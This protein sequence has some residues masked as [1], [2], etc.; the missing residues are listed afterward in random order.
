MALSSTQKRKLSIFIKCFV[1]SL[2]AWLLFALSNSYT[3]TK[4]TPVQYV[5]EPSS[6]AIRALQSDTVRVKLE[7][8]GWLILF[9]SLIRE[10]Q[11][12][13]VDLSGLENRSMVL[14]SNQIGFINR[15]FPASQKVLAVSPDT[16]FFDF[17]RQYEKRVP[18][19]LVQQLKFEKQYGIIGEVVS[20]PEYVTLFGPK[21]EVEQFESWKTDTLFASNLKTSLRRRVGLRQANSGNVRVYPHQVEVAVPVG[22]VTE[23]TFEIP[24]KAIN[25]SEYRNIRLVPSKVK[26]TALVSL[27][28]FHTLTAENFEI[29]ADFNDWKN[30]QIQTLP[31]E[32]VK[33]PNFVKIISIQPQNLDF[34]V[35]Q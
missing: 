7:S 5:N 3:Y 34:L 25:K 29:Q 17:S 14:F 24:V 18:V 12:I 32:M 33:S 22:E 10:E 8:S 35:I 31:V 1:L 26:V 13:Q 4:I 6:K 15:Q 19:E 9:S 21:E 2:L 11:K 23:K 20:K 27:K 16:L 28:D 30:W